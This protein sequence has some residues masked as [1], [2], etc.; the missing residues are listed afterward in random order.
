MSEINNF[1][2]WELKWEGKH[3]QRF[4]DWWGRNPVK[5]RLYFSRL[6]GDA[7][8]DEINHYIPLTGTLVDL[9]AG[10]GY[11]VEKLLQR[12]IDTL[13]VDSSAASVDFL[14]QRFR[15]K[16][17]FLGAQASPIEK[18][19]VRDETAD[20]VL[21][22]ETVEHLDDKILS[23]VLSEAYRILRS[24]GVIVVTT[25]HEENL[26]ENQI[27]CPNCGCVFHS[28][29]HV[30][31]LSATSLKE[32]LEIAGFKTVVSKPTLFSWHSSLIRPIHRF[33]YKLKRVSLPHLLYI[34]RKP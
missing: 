16:P 11:M 12:G 2:A 13:A 28:V 25:P 30:R 23:K 15:E 19:S 4:W 29:Q 33:V 24:S 31:S 7:I 22:I 6:V 34:G 8:L 5:S 10:P 3:V 9:G 26:A 20:I 21:L 14:N 17:H 27:I 32:I 1:E 18:M